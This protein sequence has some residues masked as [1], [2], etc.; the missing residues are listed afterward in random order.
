MATKRSPLN[1]EGYCSNEERDLHVAKRQKNNHVASVPQD[2]SSGIEVAE[3]CFL[4]A[5]LTLNDPPTPPPPPP[6]LIV[7]DDMD[8]PNLI[9]K[10]LARAVRIG[11]DATLDEINRIAGEQDVHLGLEAPRV[12]PQFLHPLWQSRKA[13]AFGFKEP[14]RFHPFL[15]RSRYWPGRRFKQL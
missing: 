10:R 6:I 8:T 12:W 2:S 11:S 15:N 5:K 14:E 13:A 7:T 9:K 4:M 1:D 3:L